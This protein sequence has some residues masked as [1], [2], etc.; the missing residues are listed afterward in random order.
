MANYIDNK[1]FEDLI[2]I[3]ASGDKSVQNEL[4]ELFDILIEHI[5]KGFNFK[6][7]R[8]EA[9]QECLLLILKVLK[10]FNKENG[11]AFNYFSTIILNN[12]RLIF[13][14]NK[15]YLQKI[16]SYREIRYGIYN[17]LSTSGLED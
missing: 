11:K 15:K 8:E 6:V 13:T 2:Q 7:D 12:L 16:E 17:E 9:K 10:N 3:Y 1:K 14:K 4:F 5:M